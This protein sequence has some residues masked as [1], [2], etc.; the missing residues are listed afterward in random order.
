MSKRVGVHPSEKDQAAQEIKAAIKGNKDLR[1]LERYQTILMVLRGESYPNI[2]EVVGRR[3]STLYN[4]SK[5]YRE[6]GLDGLQRDL[7]TGRNRKLTPDQEEKVYQTIVNQTPVD[8]GFPVERN[9][10]APIINKWIKQEFNISY[11][12]RGVRALL[13]R[14]NLSFTKPTYTLAKADPVK[15]EAFKEEFKQLKKLLDGE[16][17]HIL[18]ED[19]PMIRDYQALS[20]TWFAKGQQKIIPTYGKHWGAKLIGTLDYET[21]EVFCIQEE[22]YTAKEFLSFLEKVIDKYNGEKI[23]M[24]LDNARIHH[25]KRIQPFLEQHK[26]LLTLVYLPP[27]SPNLNMI[28]ELWGWLKSSVINNVFFDSVQKIRKAVQG[29][30]RHIN[31][32]PEVTMNRLCMQF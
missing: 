28:E 13:Y 19:E 18:F 16:I 32:T 23:V 22:R 11:S 25:A 4:Y 26:N 20:R 9:W 3:I 1:M 12:D 6:G 7:P 5:A 10:T 17:D 24:I 15:Q 8:V 30:V 27:Y 21:G 29:F 31:K 14:L 2:A